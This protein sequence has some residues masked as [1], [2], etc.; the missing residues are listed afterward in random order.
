MLA[1]KKTEA[2]QKSSRFS[3]VQEDILEENARNIAKYVAQARELF[4]VARSVSE[5][6]S[7]VLYYY[8][9]LSLAE[10]LIMSMYHFNDSERSVKGFYTHGL[11]IDRNT[12]NDV[13]VKPYGTFP[14]LHD[15]YSTEPALYLARNSFSIK[16]L[17]SVNPDLRDEYALIYG[18]KPNIQPAEGHIDVEREEYEIQPIRGIKMDPIDSILMTMFILSSKARYRPNDWIE[19]ITVKKESFVLRSFL[20]H[21]ERR[22]PNLVLNKIWG[23]VFLFGTVGRWA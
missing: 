3:V 15:C 10:A 14:R 18:E 9:M 23:E 8:G 19:E 17:L 16:E 5:L 11:T 7:P 12:Y 6:A 2:K 21:A 1:Q 22:Y 20:T 4:Q 13:I